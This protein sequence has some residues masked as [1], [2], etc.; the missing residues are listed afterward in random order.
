MN[1]RSYVTEL[2]P[3]SDEERIMAASTFVNTFGNGL[4]SVTSALYF[5][6]IVGVTPLQLG[7][8]FSLAAGIGLAMTLPMGHLSDRVSPKRLNIWL[9]TVSAFGMATYAMAT[10]Y[11]MFLA[12][13]MFL[14]VSDQGGRASRNTLIAR[15]GA[16][17]KVRFRA[18][19]RAV[20]NLGIAL[21]SLVG[22]LALV[23]DVPAVYRGII[24]ADALTTLAAARFLRKLP[25]TPPLRHEVKP[26]RTEALRDHTYV[27]LTFVNAGLGMHFMLLELVVPLWIVNHTDA[28]RWVAAGT[29]LVNTIACV[30]FTVRVS[31]G[32][33]DLRGAARLQRTGGMWLAFGALAYAGASLSDSAVTAGLIMLTA[34]GIHVLGE[35]QQSAASFGIGFNLPPEHLQGQYQGV[36]SLGWGL[37]ALAGPI[38][39]TYLVFHLGIAGWGI[40]AGQFVL[41]G[42]V[43]PWLVERALNDRRRNAEVA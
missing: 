29:Y 41:L 33:E 23:V 13:A 14:A 36:W 12:T 40:L 43:T 8:A 31:R 3:R 9:S 4:F 10:N 26:K 25:E 1:V 7:F 35:L 19:Q 18:Y 27:V 28:P 21:G 17:N 5:T 34:A 39:L 38:W 22:G 11:A 15:L 20:T 6:R 16:E 42:L 24:V 30:V 32:A 37:M 2:L